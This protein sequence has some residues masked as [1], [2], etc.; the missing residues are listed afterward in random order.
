MG[1]DPTLKRLLAKAYLNGF[2]NIHRF[3]AEQM[4]R[5][6]SHPKL[7]GQKASYKDFKTSQDLSLRCYTPHTFDQQEVL[8]VVI[9]LSASAFVID[10][11]DAS[12]DYCSLLAN[13]LNMKVINVSH[14]LAPEHK[15]PR[16]LIDC[17]ESI[18]W[19]F[20][21]ATQC[22]IDPAKIALWGES[23]GGS[24]AATCTHLLRDE[25]H[26]P[27]QHLTLFYPMVDLVSPFPSKDEFSFGF[28][29]DSAFIEWL[30]SIGF[31][32]TQ[33]RADP[34][35]S[36]LLSANFKNL[37]KATIITAEFDPLRDEGEA[38][39]QKCI[40]AGVEVKHQRFE[41]M[42]HGFMRFYSKVETAKTALHFACDALKEH[43]ISQ[44]LSTV[45]E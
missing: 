15:F 6:L 2:G 41:G 29:L 25:G 8:P 33:D 24:I 12:N 3:S 31:E 27:I 36:P 4:R 39:V 32:P 19:I 17:M 26:S 37:P 38:Y 20:Q 40:D 23:S 45:R 16:F 10:R 7:K 34:L 14:R 42:I 22:A 44:S 5:Y 13:T 28:M 11:L 21:N 18:Q 9:Y 43:F 1:L 35:V 30:D